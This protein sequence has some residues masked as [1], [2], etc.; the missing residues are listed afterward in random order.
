V[1][2]IARLTPVISAAS[3]AVAL[4]VGTPA[5]AQ[6]RPSSTGP[7]AEAA[8]GG[9]GFVGNAG[10]Y[11]AIGPSFGLRVGLDV[12]PWLSVGV[13]VGASIHEAKV[14]PPPEGEIYQLYTAIAEAR[15]TVPIRRFAIFAHGGGGL[16]AIS[17][18]VLDKVGIVE[19]DQHVTPA[20]S[21]GGGV[22]YQLQNRHYA[23]G[24]SGEYTMYPAFDAA[25][26]V[27]VRTFLRYTY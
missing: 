15:V 6:S 13:A 5:A 26:A 24:L 18:N 10:R 8:L 23:F 22:E 17:T 16:G 14:P 25:S 20:L 2:R 3:F 1:T 11:S 7:Y 27:S 9:G 12:W 21:A 4:A 19:P